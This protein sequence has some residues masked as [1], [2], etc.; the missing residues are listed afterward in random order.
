MR[1]GLIFWAVLAV[2]ALVAPFVWRAWKKSRLADKVYDNAHR[3]ANNLLDD[4]QPAAALTD[5]EYD[6]THDKQYTY[7][8]RDIDALTQRIKPIH[9]FFFEWAPEVAGFEIRQRL[10]P[11]QRNL[12]NA[13][14]QRLFGRISR[15]GLLPVYRRDPN[16]ARMLSE[17]RQRL[18]VDTFG[19]LLELYCEMYIRGAPVLRQ[20]VAAANELLEQLEAQLDELTER[21]WLEW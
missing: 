10:T 5:D 19:P 1:E 14:W 13:E 2:L 15:D 21:K 18:L 3:V 20:D 12:S 7:D 9:K 16:I 11:Q 4:D 8:H 6:H 17:D